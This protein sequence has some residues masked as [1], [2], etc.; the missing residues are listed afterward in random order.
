MVASCARDAIDAN[1]LIRH[2][3]NESIS[4]QSLCVKGWLSDLFETISCFCLMRHHCD[5]MGQEGEQPYLISTQIIHSN[6]ITTLLRNALL[7]GRA[8]DDYTYTDWFYGY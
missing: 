2:V 6:G 4:P 3:H 7:S 8:P 1:A 5:T